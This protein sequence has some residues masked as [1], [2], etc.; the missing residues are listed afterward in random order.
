MNVCPSWSECLEFESCVCCC[1][2]YR[3]LPVWQEMLTLSGT[4]EFTPF[5]EFMILPIHLYTYSTEFVSLRTMVTDLLP[6]LVWL[7]VSD[8]F[9][10]QRLG[11]M[12]NCIWLRAP[13]I[14]IVV[15]RK[16]KGIVSRIH[17]KFQ[18]KTNLIWAV[19]ISIPNNQSNMSRHN[20]NTEQPIQ[21]EPS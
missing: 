14:P 18:S 6:G 16:E 9:C 4:P 21:Y 11:A 13:K 2:V 19:I 17:Y 8:L 10:Y 15:F 20:I 5:L 3:N 7:L 1:G 12:Q